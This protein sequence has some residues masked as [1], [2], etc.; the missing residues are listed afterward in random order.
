MTLYTIQASKFDS[1]YPNQPFWG[2]KYAAALSADSHPIGTDLDLK[3][4]WIYVYEVELLT[5]GLYPH[6]FD[7][8][9]IDHHLYFNGLETSH[10]FY[11]DLSIGDWNYRLFQGEK[12]QKRLL[13]AYFIGYVAKMNGIELLSFFDANQ[14]EF[15]IIQS[16]DYSKLIDE[17][18]DMSSDGDIFEY[19][20]N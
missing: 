16:W 12:I 9:Q 3:R 11:Y 17:Y 20:N 13:D 5:D 15:K 1:Y 7:Y 6:I 19:N 2:D 14:Y 18:D 4:E 8:K 10:D